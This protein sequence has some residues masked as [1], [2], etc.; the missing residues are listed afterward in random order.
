VVAR[1]HDLRELD[2]R[3]PLC[4]RLVLPLVARG[5]EIAGQDDD[6]GLDAP[7]ALDDRVQRVGRQRQRPAEVDVADLRDAQRDLRER[8]RGPA[9]G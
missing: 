1:D 4:S 3:G 5:R 6:V 9:P 2:L 7:D 8:G